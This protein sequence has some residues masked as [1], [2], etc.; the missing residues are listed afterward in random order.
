[1]TSTVPPSLEL[2]TIALI[3][4]GVEATRFYFA[5]SQPDAARPIIILGDT[6]TGSPLR[7]PAVAGQLATALLRRLPGF[8]RIHPDQIDWYL[9]GWFRELDR[10]AAREPA[11]SARR[12]LQTLSFRIVAS[13]TCSTEYRV[14]G[15]ILSET[16]CPDSL[17]LALEAA[18]ERR[19][20]TGR[21]A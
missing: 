8:T 13:E 2:G 10:G 17:L 19:Y 15:P 12:R 11:Q 6:A 16:A 14:A 21:L 9:T 5:F 1:M 20:D 4:E 18:Y 3:G 7:T